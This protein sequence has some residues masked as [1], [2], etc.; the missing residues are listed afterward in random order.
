MVD[1]RCDPTCVTALHDR[2][3]TRNREETLGVVAGAVRWH[4]NVD[5]MRFHDPTFISPARLV[6]SLVVEAVCD[7]VC[8]LPFSDVVLEKVFDRVLKDSNEASPAVIREIAAALEAEGGHRAHAW[9][10]KPAMVALVQ[11][12]AARLRRSY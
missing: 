9:R 11:R 8:A 1:V 12:V 5:T 7:H 6:A 4:H 2:R 3:C 10:D